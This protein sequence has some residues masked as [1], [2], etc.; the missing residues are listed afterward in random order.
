MRSEE[1][2][3]VG[4]VNYEKPTAADLGPAAPVVGA[5]CADGQTFESRGPCGP[6]GNSAFERGCGDGFGASYICADGYGN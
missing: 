6:V 3:P 5:S 2:R 4:K 1:E